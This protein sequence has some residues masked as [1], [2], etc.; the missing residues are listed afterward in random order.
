NVDK[1]RNK[2]LLIDITVPSDYNIGAKE[3]EKLTKYHLLKSKVSRLWNT[4]T[5]VIPIVIGATKIV[6]KT[7]KKYIDHLETSIDIS[8]LQKQ[9]AIHTSL[10]LSRVLDNTIFVVNTPDPFK[11]ICSNLKTYSNL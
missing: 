9:A 8:I 4:Q 1:N 11:Q 10:I 2:T 3:I 6:A 7:I 5:T